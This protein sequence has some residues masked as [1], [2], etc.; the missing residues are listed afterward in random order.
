VIPKQG[1]KLDSAPELFYLWDMVGNIFG[2]L[3]EANIRDEAITDVLRRIEAKG[4]VPPA[5][6]ARKDLG[7]YLVWIIIP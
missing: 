2:L 3:R 1:S 5:H 6:P 7:D 4:M